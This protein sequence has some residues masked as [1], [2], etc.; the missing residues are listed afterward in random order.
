MNDYATL[1]HT[2][3]IP[4]IDYTTLDLRSIKIE[5][6]IPTGNKR[7]RIKTIDID[8]E[9]LKYSSR[10]GSSLASIY[11]FSDSIFKYF[12]H[13]EVLDRLVERTSKDKIN[14]AIQLNKSGQRTILA[15]SQLT[16]DMIK[17]DDLHD[18]FVNTSF[19][20]GKV[21]YRNGVVISTHV[22][23]SRT[24]KI[25]S[26]ELVDR[27]VIETPIDGYGDPSAYLGFLRQICAN[28]AV[29]YAKA[30][31]SQIKMGSGKKADGAIPTLR[32]FIDT[33]RNEEGFSALHERLA[34]ALTSWAS[35]DEAYNIFKLIT[36][37]DMAVLHRNVNRG[38]SANDERAALIDADHVRYGTIFSSDLVDRFK[39]LTGDS[40]AMYGLISLDS[41]GQKQR[42]KIPTKATVYDLVNF[43]T[44]IATH[45]AKE[46]LNLSRRINGW[47]GETLSKEFDLEG[48]KQNAEDA[49]DLFATQRS[50]IVGG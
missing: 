12:D 39:G 8:G 9:K 44:E 43:A 46:E 10:F 11:G 26:D 22:P 21:S 31:K 30:F 37:S 50:E 41:M 42:R 45:R 49:T 29:G 40:A 33:Y 25:G 27:F 5:T 47:V 2:T 35:L 14:V 48:T 3:A 13:K 16:R 24:F 17:A 19:D 28:G 6:E 36:T 20:H 4:H 23:N 1:T 15:A 34:S 32:R 18:L 38:P 7:P